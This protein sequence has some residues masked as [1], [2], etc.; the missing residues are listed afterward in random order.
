MY[1]LDLCFASQSRTIFEKQYELPGIT[2]ENVYICVC[3]MF[4]YG[5]L[6]T[7]RFLGPFIRNFFPIHFICHSNYS[8]FELVLCVVTDS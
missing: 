4:T 6:K 1:M 3:F 7:E 2:I 8:E 5:Y